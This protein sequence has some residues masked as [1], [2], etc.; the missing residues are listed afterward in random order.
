MACGTDCRD[1]VCLRE[2]LYTSV[3]PTTCAK[4][5]QSLMEI[6]LSICFSLEFFG[7]YDR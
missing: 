1:I 3:G 4:L 6:L 7:V 5:F 2:F